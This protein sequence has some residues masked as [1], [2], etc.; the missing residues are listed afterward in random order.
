MGYVVQN[1]NTE[2]YNVL[3]ISLESNIE[4]LERKIELTH[5]VTTTSLHLAIFLKQAPK[6]T[7]KRTLRITRGYLDYSY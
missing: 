1:K 5:S 2:D 3:K 6:A 4:A 7:S